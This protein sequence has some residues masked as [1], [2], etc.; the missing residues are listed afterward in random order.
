MSYILTLNG[1]LAGISGTLL[2]DIASVLGGKLGVVVKPSTRFIGRWIAYFFFGKF[3]HNDIR[4]SEAK[5]YECQ[6]GV[7]T[8]YLIGVAHL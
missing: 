2:M 8:H 5:P 6:L 7:I 3:K 1:A 4:R